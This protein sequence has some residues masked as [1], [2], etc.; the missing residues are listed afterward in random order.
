MISAS[1]RA[2]PGGSTALRTRW[3]RR[4]VFVYVP[5]ISAKVAAGRTTSARAA[6]S[7]MKMSC[8]TRNSTSSR[9]RRVLLALAS[10]ITVFSPMM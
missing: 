9:A 5:S 3:T 8:T 1:G 10:L 2:R 6:V 7:V 4:S